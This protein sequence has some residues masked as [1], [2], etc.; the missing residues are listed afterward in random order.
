[1]AGKPSLMADR[2]LQE[3]PSIGVK[4][5]AGE[6]GIKEAWAEVIYLGDDHVI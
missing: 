1:M 6:M 2:V 3:A 4:A 5:L